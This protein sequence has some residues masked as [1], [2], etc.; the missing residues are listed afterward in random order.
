MKIN[1]QYRVG[2]PGAIPHHEK[3]TKQIN[4]EAAALAYESPVAAEWVSKTPGYTGQSIC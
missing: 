4:P 2:V 1:K 3:Q